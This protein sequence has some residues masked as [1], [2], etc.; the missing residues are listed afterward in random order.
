LR[1]HHPAARIAAS[2]EEETVGA[3]DR[4]IDL[5]HPIEAG[6]TTYPGLPAPEIRQH[7]TR[8]A[9]RGHYGPGVEFRIDVITL[10]GNTGT[11]VDSP[12]HRH[13][14]GADL[15][16]LPLERLVDVPAVRI[17]VTGST[18]RGVDAAAFGGHELA[19]MAVLVHTGFDRHWR[20]AAYARDNPYL[21]RGAAEL[22]VAAGAA[23][24]GID[25]LNIDDT[26][27]PARPAHSLLLAAGIPI[28]EHL[29]NLG[30][31]PPAGARFTALPPPVVDLVTAPVRAVARVPAGA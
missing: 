19:G 5:S 15:A 25:S 22:L 9:S 20:T 23:I 30:E 2:H 29:T 18:T 17:D 16:A 8:E 31:V 10:C 13:A 24:V 27:D 7:L 21:T 26:G 11:Y 3:R 1:V 28:C 14:D 12:A 6:M 4:L